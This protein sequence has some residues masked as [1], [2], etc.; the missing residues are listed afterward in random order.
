MRVEQPA[1]FP[2]EHPAV[3]ALEA[4]IGV[5]EMCANV[6]QRRRPDQGIAD[7][8]QQHIGIG[9]AVEAAIV[10]NLDAADDEPAPR[11]E[12]VNVK[13]LPDSLTPS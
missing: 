2:H 7:G 3:S 6:T 9:V 10:R 1:H 4:R 5:R 11:D 12:R 8:V 13:S